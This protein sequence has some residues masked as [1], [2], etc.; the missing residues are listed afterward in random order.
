MKMSALRV[1]GYS[2]LSAG[3]TAAPFFF[4]SLFIVVWFSLV[5]LLVAMRGRSVWTAYGS[6]LL[7]GFL[8]FASVA[9]WVISFLHSANG[10]PWLWAIIAASLYWFFCAHIFAVPA[11][12]TA[13][14]GHRR[15]QLQWLIFACTGTSVFTYFPQVFPVDLSVTQGRFLPALQG[16]D[17]TGSVG[18]HFMILLHNGLLYSLLTANR[19]Q[20]GRGHFQARLHRYIGAGVL[21]TWFFYGFYTCLSAG[22]PLSSDF[23]KVGIVQTNSPDTIAVPPLEPGYSRAYSPALALSKELVAEG[24]ELIVWP[25]MRY[26]GFY[27]FPHVRSA[28]QA[29]VSEEQVPLLFQELDSTTGATYSTSV[30]LTP[31]GN[32]QIYEKHGLIPFGEYLP[33]G[34]PPALSRYLLGDFQGALSPGQNAKTFVWRALSMQ[35]LICYESSLPKYVTHLLNRQQEKPQLLVVQSNDGWFGTSN[36]VNLHLVTGQLRGVEH[37]LPVLHVVKDGPSWLTSPIGEKEYVT[38]RGLR[39]GYV[40]N[41]RALPAAAPTW[42]ARHPELFAGVIDVLS[43]LIMLYGL[44]TRSGHVRQAITSL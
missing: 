12:L 16:L 14:V 8:L 24:V 36:Q 3:L 42:Y 26:I 19:G 34:F 32:T 17:I 2:A 31:D 18:L 13:W 6:G 28:L 40:V 39:A 38:D 25:E 41:V 11:I 30:F 10:V 37:R 5:P 1:L 23:H 43:V 44:V 27:D 29:F 4:E 33:F 20:R 35:P 7:F 9:H 15:P 22:E 21:I